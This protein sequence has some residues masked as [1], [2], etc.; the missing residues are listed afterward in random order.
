LTARSAAADRVFVNGRIRTLAADGP[1]VVESLACWRGRIVGVGSRTDIQPWVQAGTEVVDLAGHT[2]LPG[3]IETH[4]HPLMAGIAM[5]QPPVGTPPC[6]TVADVVA[7]IGRHART[8]PPGKVIESWG[9]DDSLVADDR[10]LTRADLDAATTVHPVVIRHVSGHLA[11][12]NTLLLERAGIT[13]DTPDEPGGRIVRDAGGEPTGELH[14]RAMGLIQHVVPAP[15]SEEYRRALRAISERCLSRGVTS[16]SDAGVFNAGM[17]TAYQDALASGELRV[18]ARLFPGWT[19]LDQLPT[20]T[21]FGNDDLRIGALKLIAD[22]SIQGYTGCLCQPYHDRPDVFGTEVI[23]PGEL[24]DLV[25]RAHAAGFQVAI[26]TNG[27]KAIDNALDAFEAAL[28]ETPRPDHRHRLEHAQTV[29]DDQ[30]VRM[31][32]LGVVASVFVNHVWYWGDRHRDRF[33]G[34][35]RASRISPLRSFADH[36]V[37][38]A[39][40]CDDPVTPVDPLFTIWAAVNRITRDG[41][42]LGPEQRVDA[43]AAVRGYTTTAAFLG[44]EEPDKGSLEVGKLADLV[45]LGA[46]PLA[47]DPR[48]IKDIPV[49]ATVVDG[50]VRYRNGL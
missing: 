8:T 23:A 27:D 38:F 16:V 35:D 13:A 31:Q 45:V 11:Y 36:G 2:V 32:R 15:G 47:C 25:A 29:R 17:L 26:H 5:G 21:G 9:Y 3:F 14:E 46:D 50:E 7:S 12:V 42:E 18:R 4:M 34:P 22:G 20:R 30:L 28:R 44:F 40:H 10:P 6:D 49:V 39:L 19:M 37:P 33:L 41:E 43:A 1:E 48:S 24:S